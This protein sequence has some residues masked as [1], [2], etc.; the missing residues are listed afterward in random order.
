MTTTITKAKPSKS[1]VTPISTAM[2]DVSRVPAEIAKRA[3][4]IIQTMDRDAFFDLFTAESHPALELALAGKTPA[5]WKAWADWQIVERTAQYAANK[6]RQYSRPKTQRADGKWLPAP[7]V[8]REKDALYPK[9]NPMPK[10]AKVKKSPP[11]YTGNVVAFPE[12]RRVR[13]PGARPRG[14]NR[15]A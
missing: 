5:T 15:A 14:P 4:A 13:R 10:A 6:G 11:A 2:R 1:N 7:L 8:E 3:H 12:H 9:D